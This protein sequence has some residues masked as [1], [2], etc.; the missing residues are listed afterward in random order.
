MAGVV[1]NERP[2]PSVVR[3]EVRVRPRREGMRV[4]SGTGAERS[5]SVLDKG[6]WVR[7]NPPVAPAR[8]EPKR[9]PTPTQDQ[10][11]TP[12]RTE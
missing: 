7:C 6:E 10:R 9:A 12:E 4:R 3:T 2:L 11:Q 5:E 1:R 8:S